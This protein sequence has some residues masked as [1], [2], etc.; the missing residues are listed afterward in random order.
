[1]GQ[2]TRGESRP[3]SSFAALRVSAGVVLR[4][5][6]S[7]AHRPRL[8]RAAEPSVT[9]GAGAATPWSQRKR[10]VAHERRRQAAREQRHSVLHQRRLL[11]SRWRQQPVPS[12]GSYLKQLHHLRVSSP[13]FHRLLTHPPFHVIQRGVSRDPHH[14]HPQLLSNIRSFLPTPPSPLSSPSSFP[15]PSP[16]NP[17]GHLD[18]LDYLHYLDYLDYLTLHVGNRHWRRRGLQS[19]SP[20][21]PGSPSSSI[22]PNQLVASRPRSLPPLRRRMSSVIFAQDQRSSTLRLPCND[23]QFHDFIATQSRSLTLVGG[24]GILD[25]PPRRLRNNHYDGFREQSNPDCSPHSPAFSPPRSLQPS[26]RSP[27]STPLFDPRYGTLPPLK[28]SP[29]P[30]L[31]NPVSPS[32]HNYPP[33]PPRS[34]SVDES[35][36]PRLWDTFSHKSNRDQL[37]LTPRSQSSGSRSSNLSFRGDPSSELEFVSEL[38]NSGLELSSLLSS[39]STD[40]REP[41]YHCNTPLVSPSLQQPLHHLPHNDSTSRRQLTYDS[42]S[43]PSPPF[44]Q[45][46]AEPIDSVRLPGSSSASHSSS[47]LLPTAGNGATSTMAGRSSAV[48]DGDESDLEPM[49]ALA[50]HLEP[51]Q[52]SS[53]VEWYTLRQL[54]VE[55]AKAT[56]SNADSHSCRGKVGLAQST[57]LLA[58]HEDCPVNE[59]SRL[60]YTVKWP[61]ENTHSRAEVTMERPFLSEESSSLN[62]PSS[63][64]LRPVGVTS[65]VDPT[66]GNVHLVDVLFDLAR[67]NPTL[68]AIVGNIPLMSN[69]QLMEYSR[70]DVTLFAGRLLPHSHGRIGERRIGTGDV[71]QVHVALLYPVGML[72][73]GCLPP[74]PEPVVFFTTAT[75]PVT[76]AHPVLL[77]DQPSLL[78]N[79][80]YTTAQSVGEGYS[81]GEQSCIPRAVSLASVTF[82]HM[83]PIPHAEACW[84][85]ATHNL[86]PSNSDVKTIFVA[87]PESSPSSLT[88]PT[89]VVYQYLSND[90]NTLSSSA[91]IPHSLRDQNIRSA[92]F[93][94]SPTSCRCQ[95]YWPRGRQYSV[96]LFSSI[97]LWCCPSVSVVVFVDSFGE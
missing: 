20:S 51:S 21:T 91:I 86:D 85:T 89:S 4:D 60:T 50:S 34:A 49:S 11:Q 12:L 25:F 42:P 6:G 56:A 71:V 61:G 59:Q 2:L 54:R 9:A 44:L 43:P 48:F 46:E 23:G 58:F 39:G 80:L 88:T 87:L 92:A 82:R 77:Q 53:P 38:S 97:R 83:T 73:S 74:P 36:S 57:I 19:P 72:R 37:R 8:L 70:E 1:M 68:A 95:L 67:L 31:F 90:L 28:S 84:Y 3:F 27:A 75:A 33:S 13:G 62:P 5:M 22:S 18:P 26:P 79:P 10:S 47:F 35:V 63:S 41:F 78:S 14:L 93:I 69:S 52:S 15:F 64:T 7:G 45:M 30:F 96:S 16:I 81:Q 40:I 66:A 94:Y 32:S 24:P 55:V 65:K 29:S 17:P 76:V